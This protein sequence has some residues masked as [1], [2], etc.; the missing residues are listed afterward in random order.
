M[1]E[2]VYWITH[3]NK[4]ILI[5][6]V[7]NLKEKEY[8]QEVDKIKDVIIKEKRKSVLYISIV[9]N[10]YTT[11]AIKKKWEWFNQMTHEYLIASTI[12]GITGIQRLIASAIKRD[13]KFARN[14][15]EAKEW[16]VKQ[17]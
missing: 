5:G 10:T 15:N 17:Q 1:D 6:D 8:L 16:L 13:L 11:D 12:V 9:K 7:S 3:E 4:K 2:R 14:I